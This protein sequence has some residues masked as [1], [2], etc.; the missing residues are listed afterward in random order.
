[1]CC[2]VFR[3]RL[4][5]SA[6]KLSDPIWANHRLCCL[7]ELRNPSETFLCAFWNFCVWILGKKVGSSSMMVQIQQEKWIKRPNRPDVSK[8]FDLDAK[9]IKIHDILDLNGCSKWL[10]A[11]RVGRRKLECKTS[12]WCART[13]LGGLGMCTGSFRSL[14]L[15]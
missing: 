12:V 15:E 5:S 8:S 11:I 7:L 6:D 10:D 2:I 4:R 13:P 9:S 14:L 1:M 3:V